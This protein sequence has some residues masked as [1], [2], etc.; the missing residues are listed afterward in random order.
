MSDPRTKPS[1]TAQ[2]LIT[3]T[4]GKSDPDGPFVERYTDYTS[5]VVSGG[6]SFVS[7]PEC[8]IEVPEM[9]GVFEESPLSI[10]ARAATELLK[11]LSNGEPFARVEVEVFERYVAPDGSE[12]VQAAFIGRLDHTVRNK[13]GKA[14]IVELVARTWKDSDLLVPFGL[15]AN[16]DCGHALGDDNC[17]VVVTVSVGTVVKID[18]M[19]VDIAGLPPAPWE[20]FYFNGF[21]ERQGLRLRIRQT[22]LGATRFLLSKPAPS[23]WLNQQVRVTNGCRK[24]VWSCRDYENESEFGGYGAGI[25]NYHPA[26][27]QPTP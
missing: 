16:S 19:R 27:E 22:S 17:G 15:F 8:E 10:T 9:T 24:K 1:K 12:S 23:D 6:H 26:Y 2:H 20:H 7:I 4:W 25:P 13:D 14:A 3:L 21:L 11:R 5:D 18:S